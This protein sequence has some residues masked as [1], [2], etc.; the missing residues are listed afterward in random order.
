V[1]TTADARAALAQDLEQ[2]EELVPLGGV[3]TP[4]DL[5]GAV[6]TSGLEAVQQ[7]AA[8]I[9]EYHQDRS[10]IAGIGVADHEPGRLEG[11]DHGRDRPG[12]DVELGG[13]IGHAQGP[14]VGGDEPKHAGL[15][16]GQAQRGELHDRPPTEPARGVREQFGQLEGG[17]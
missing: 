5:V 15:G 4:E 3:E 7:V 2:V 11:V 10:A 14:P 12:D 16:I 8:I 1:A 9:A 17:I 13:E 6:P